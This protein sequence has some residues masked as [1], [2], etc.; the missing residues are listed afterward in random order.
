MRRA[1]YSEILEVV[2][3]NVLIS[4][5]NLLALLFIISVPN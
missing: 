3:L 2:V 5:L 4:N 1:E